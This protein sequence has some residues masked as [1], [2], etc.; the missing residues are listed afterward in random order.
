MLDA[1]RRWERAGKTSSVEELERLAAEDRDFVEKTEARV[2]KLRTEAEQR[3]VVGAKREQLQRRIDSLEG[4][5][6]MHGSYRALHAAYSPTGMRLWLLSELLEALVAGLN[7]IARTSR[8]RVEF[9]YRLGRNRDLVITAS[10]LQGTFDVRLLS[11]A[12]A[13]LFCLSLLSV[14]LPMLPSRRRSS[15]LVLD[16]LDGNCDSR[17]RSLISEQHLP[18]LARAVKSLIVIT[19]ASRDEFDHPRATNLT[20]E[21]RGGV[22][23]LLE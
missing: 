3:R 9:G 6:A 2:R 1:A 20:V 14:L 13:N 21:K 4:E 10:N 17:T 7:E 15:L 18:R 22:S 5:V 23:R 11:G 19:P 12:E 8:D 16:E